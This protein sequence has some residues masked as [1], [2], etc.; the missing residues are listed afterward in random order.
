MARK[1]QMEIAA[2]VQ[3]RSLSPLPRNAHSVPF[4]ELRQSLASRVSAISLF[5]DQLMRFI[6]KFRNAD[7]SKTDIAMALHESLFTTVIQSN[8]ETSCNQANV[9][10]RGDVDGDLSITPPDE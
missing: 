10:R 2:M 8:V 3:T 4:V 6:L 9:T 1:F 5:V 7:G